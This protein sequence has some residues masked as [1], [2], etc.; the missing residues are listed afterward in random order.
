M[1]LSMIA[2]ASSNKYA[3]HALKLGHLTDGVFEKEKIALFI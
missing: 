2:M 1:P 3:K